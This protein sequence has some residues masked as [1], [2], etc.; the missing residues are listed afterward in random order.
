[1]YDYRF[2]GQ[3]H[4][5]I[6]GP[7]TGKTTRLVEK[8]VNLAGASGSKTLVCC[9]TQ[10]QAAALGAQAGQ[11]GL[12]EGADVKFS[13]VADMAHEI[14]ATPQAQAIT[15]RKGHVLS[16]YEERVLLEDMRTSTMK[17]KRLKE[18]LGFL[19][20]QFS[21]LASK[22]E[23]GV[24]V[25][26]EM[27]LD[28]LR[29]NLDFTGGVLRYE[30]ASLALEALAAS[31]ELQQRFSYDNVLV[32]EYGLLSRGMQICAAA[33]ATETL[34]IASDTVGGRTAPLPFCYAQGVQ[35][36]IDANEGAQVARA[37]DSTQTKQIADALNAVRNSKALAQDQALPVAGRADDERSLTLEVAGDMGDELKE[38]ALRVHQAMSDGRSIAV[39]GTN[40]IWRANV[41]KTLD[42]LSI[43]VQAP[44]KKLAIKDFCNQRQS[45]AVRE[46]A[47]GMLRHDKSDGV[48]WRTIFALGDYV[49]RSVGMTQL[50]DAAA[51]KGLDM[52]ATLDALSADKT[53]IGSANS[54][55][56]EIVGIYEQTL[57]ELAASPAGQEAPN[58]EDDK[59]GVLVCR[60]ED[61]FGKHV[62]CIVFGGFVD[63]FIPSRAYFDSS[64]MLGA[65]KE[66]AHAHD[67][68]LLH[69][70]LGSASK[71][72]VFTSFTHASLNVAEPLQLCIDRIY[73]KD[74]MRTCR[75]HTSSLGQIIGLTEEP[76]R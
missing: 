37:E 8:L 34:T 15:Q 25:E 32:D 19:F 1:M 71:Q 14:I 11:I 52:L 27:I 76:G 35:D 23:W 50:K 67:L 39:V 28:L 5:I 22:E 65:K 49:A 63:G 48:A 73:L 18:L 29:K 4:C 40:K 2:S 51:A 69:L 74:G 64:Q 61:L 70:A 6:G 20:R 41:M 60:P 43:P 62:D 17:G 68:E 45:A 21:E 75:V 56:A 53:A 30:L 42:S 33:L 36:L 10:E 57:E 12:P 16:E 66:R 47:L 72:I 31:S 54:A 58:D 9:S 55:L 38:I 3:V 13:T 24:T 26:E 59:A 46:D 44:A 7:Q